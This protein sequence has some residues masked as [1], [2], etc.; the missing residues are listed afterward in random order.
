MNVLVIGSGGREHALVWKLA[1]SP[2]VGKVYCAPGNG[3][4]LRQAENIPLPV[5]DLHGL[6]AFAKG[7]GIDLTVVGPEAPLIAGIADRFR[8]E[9]LRVFGPS[10]A[11]AQLEGSKIFFKEIAAQTGIPTAQSEVFDDPD[12]AIAWLERKPDGPWVVKADGNAA[13]KGVLICDNRNEAIAAV[14]LAMVTREFGAAGDRILI[15]ER[16]EGYEVSLLALCS[17][18]DFIP[19]APAQDYKRIG[20]GDT[21]LNTGG[22]GC[23]SPMPGFPQELLDFTEQ[24]VIIPTLRAVEFTGVL[25]TGLMIT[26]Q[27][28]KVLE[29]NARFGDPETQVVL[30]RL[31]SDLAELL[32]AAADGNLGGMTAQWTPRKA[33]TVVLAAGGYPGD[34]AKGKVISGLDDAAALPDVTVFHAGTKKADGQILTNGGRVLNVTALGDTFAQAIDQAYAAVGKITWDGMTYR[35]DIAARVR[36]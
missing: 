14:E 8:R 13:G 35:R 17:G 19:L 30:P 3:G 9:G 5:S 26:P 25:Y 11:A 36:E 29:F 2:R 10:A 33:V 32:G 22:M 7:Q 1:Q 15:E 28:P 23:Y 31:A 21:G 24:R 6:A 27:G 4:T 16:L 18:Q 20:E 34:Y 12:T